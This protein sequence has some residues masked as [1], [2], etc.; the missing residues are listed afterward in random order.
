MNN[1]N[2]KLDDTLGWGKVNNDGSEI[3]DDNPLFVNDFVSLKDMLKLLFYPKKFLLYGYIAK[4]K[5][6]ARYGLKKPFRI[7]DVGCGTGSTVIDLKKMFPKIIYLNASRTQSIR[8][9]LIPKMNEIR[10]K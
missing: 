7:L 5:R 8:D 4:A 2:E 6:R 3:W 10:S 1:K 9:Q